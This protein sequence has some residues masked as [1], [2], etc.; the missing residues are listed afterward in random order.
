VD[1]LYAI[2]RLPI[3]FLAR[4]RVPWELEEVRSV[5]EEVDPR[6]VRIDA[7]A[8]ERVWQACEALYHTGAHP[9]IQVCIRREGRIVLHRALGHAAG[10]AP[11]D[12]P[13]APKVL[14]G[15]ETPFCIYSASKAIT[16]MLIHKLDEKRVLHLEDRVCDFIPE[17]GRYGKHRITLRHI[18]AHRA[19][20]P[21]LPPEAID[22][23]LL[24]QPERVT[25]IL[26]EAQPRSRPGR[27][28]AYHAVSGGFV[29]AEVVRRTTGHDI[30]QV[31]EQ[32]ILE[33][34]GFR[35]MR[36]GVKPEDVDRVA[37]NA[38]TGPPVPP[39][40]SLLLRRALG[41]GMREAVELSNDP[42]FVTG[43]IPSGNV[44]TTADELCAFYQCLL[45][46]G[47]LDGVR[48]FEPSTVRH[49]TT[50]QSYW[51]MDFTL[52]VPIRYGLGFMLGDKPISLFGADNPRAFGHLGLSNMFSWADPQRQ[53]SVAILTSGKPILSAHFV[54]VVQI[55]YE[56]GRA[57][58]KLPESALA[59]GR[60][61]AERPLGRAA[62]RSV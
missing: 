49:A 2:T 32:Q 60:E 13:D 16:A 46:E 22:L 38:F 21:N 7:S 17:F 57:F 58:P 44:V 30:R 40:L 19:G 50:E 24:T 39:P 54:R 20:I 59:R 15:L 4:C 31:L 62:G 8:V 53:L 48:V 52:I 56:I 11:D 47:A 18:L 6:E 26:C 9:A 23:D 36:Y 29:L 25:E 41:T 51:E 12:P 45:D 61:A 42:R 55:L 27:L 14:C 28:L 10:N 1:P 3:P 43:I 37:R 35:W 33:P 34:L 5:G